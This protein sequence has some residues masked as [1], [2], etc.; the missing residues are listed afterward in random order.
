MKVQ[1]IGKCN[2]RGV[3][4]WLNGWY[5]FK[6][7]KERGRFDSALSHSPFGSASL[8]S[9]VRPSSVLLPQELPL[10]F[11]HTVWR[12]PQNSGSLARQYQRGRRGISAESLRRSYHYPNHFILLASTVKNEEKYL[13]KIKTSNLWNAIPQELRRVRS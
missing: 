10:V 2:H 12:L 5:R 11:P 13:F 6:L 1:S 3:E 7:K 4:D 9:S 8:H